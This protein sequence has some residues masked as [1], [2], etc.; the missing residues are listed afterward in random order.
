MTPR[1]LAGFTRQEQCDSIVQREIERL[2]SLAIGS[3]E[4][5]DSLVSY[6]RTLPKR[7]RSIPGL[8]RIDDIISGNYRRFS[9][10]NWHHS[11][12]V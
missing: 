5:L 10:Q 12:S 4:A 6:L 11:V 3:T 1:R 8:N 2:L 7:K 9:N